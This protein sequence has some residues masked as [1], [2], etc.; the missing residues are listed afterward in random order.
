MSCT[1]IVSLYLKLQTLGKKNFLYMRSCISDFINISWFE[2]ILY[3][4][5]LQKYPNGLST[6]KQDMILQKSHLQL[7]SKRTQDHQ[8]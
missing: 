3:F 7:Y 8:F 2:N 4:C 6:I 5:I 1:F